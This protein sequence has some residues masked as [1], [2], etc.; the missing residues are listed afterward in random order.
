MRKIH[1]GDYGP[2]ECGANIR[3]CPVSNEEDHFED[4]DSAMIHYVKKL[5]EKYGRFGTQKNDAESHDEPPC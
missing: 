2:A 3:D 5:E 1:V 4:F